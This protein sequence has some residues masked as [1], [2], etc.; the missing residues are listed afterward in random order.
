MTFKVG[1]ALDFGVFR[2]VVSVDPADH[3]GVVRA[4]LLR[5]DK[6]GQGPLFQARATGLNYSIEIKHVAARRGNEIGLAR[7]AAD[8]PWSGPLILLLEDQYIGSNPHSAAKVIE[9]RTRWAFAF[10]IECTQLDVVL[11]PGSVWQAGWMG[12]G[13]GSGRDALKL[14]SDLSSGTAARK[15]GLA[16]APTGDSADAF[17]MLLWWLS[18]HLIGMP[19]RFMTSAERKRVNRA[20]KGPSEPGP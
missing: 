19:R 7:E 14:A 15:L 6:S 12:L 13:S 16:S 5:E 9:A 17:N 4:D 1:P 18:H 20:A 11:I 3:C 10:E 2:R 8:K